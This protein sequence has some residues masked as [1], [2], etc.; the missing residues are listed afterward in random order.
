MLTLDFIGYFSCYC[1][2]CCC[3]IDNLNRNGFFP[4]SLRGQHRIITFLSWNMTNF[5][6][7]NWF[8]FDLISMHFCCK[9]GYS[10]HAP[11]FYAQFLKTDKQ[12]RIAIIH[13]F[14][15][16][17]QPNAIVIF[18]YWRVSE[19]LKCLLYELVGTENGHY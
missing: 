11:F 8:S 13:R 2:R 5:R 9:N 16:C 17:V 12:H 6:P 19:Y 7:K 4:S 1:V 3:Y 18:G 10:S 14:L 15:V